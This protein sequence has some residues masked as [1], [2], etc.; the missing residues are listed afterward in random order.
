MQTYVHVLKIVFKMLDLIFGK[1]MLMLFSNTLRKET[2]L[3]VIAPRKIEVQY[4]GFKAN[5]LFFVPHNEYH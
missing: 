1:D 3:K 5:L 4:N 2:I